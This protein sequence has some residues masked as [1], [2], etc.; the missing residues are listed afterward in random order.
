MKINLNLKNLVLIGIALIFAFLYFNKGDGG[1]YSKELKSVTAQRDL[2]IAN[3]IKDHDSAAA[4]YHNLADSFDLASVRYRVADS[5]NH[6]KNTH[7]KAK[8]PRLTNS[9]RDHVRDSIFR[10]NGIPLR[11][12]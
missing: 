7:E 10:S 8:T 2:A 1:D 3:G 5:I 11:T 9:Q 6:Y 4:A 12:R